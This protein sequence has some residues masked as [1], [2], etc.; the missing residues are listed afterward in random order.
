MEEVGVISANAATINPEMV[1]KAITILVEVHAERTETPDL[2]AMKTALSGPEIQQC[3]YITGDADFVLIL[4]VS[5]MAKYGTLARG[6]FYDNKNVKWFRTI[7]VMDR[8]KTGL[9]VPVALPHSHS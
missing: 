4:K 6:L 2:D 9:N 1:G 3:Y 8:V 5:S 7:V